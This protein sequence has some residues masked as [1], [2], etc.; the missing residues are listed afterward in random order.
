MQRKDEI[1]LFG[2]ELWNRATDKVEVYSDLFTYNTAKG[3]WTQIKSKGPHPRS[4]S[5]GA[6][7]KDQLYIFGGEFTSPNQEKFKHFRHATPSAAVPVCVLN[8]TNPVWYFSL[9]S[10]ASPSM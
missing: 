5:C 2:G 7:H 6:V 8:R 10:D 3:Q 1:V 9:F 4:A